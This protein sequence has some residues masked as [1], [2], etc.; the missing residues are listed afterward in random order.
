MCAEALLSGIMLDTRNFVL[1]TGARTFE[2]AAYLKTNGAD[3]VAVKQFFANSFDNYKQ[4]NAI[5]STAV[6]YKDS[7]VAIATEQ[8][9]DIRI[10]ASQVANELLNVAGVKASYVLFEENG[11]INISARSLG[12]RN[13]QVIMERL[14]G[15]GH[16][17]MAATQLSGITMGDAVVR[18]EEAINEFYEEL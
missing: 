12:E 17:S 3:T 5:V 10:I 1:S 15:G 2:A 11:Q 6:T 4:K 16:L 13:V 7:A 18:L 9:N 8:S 14:G